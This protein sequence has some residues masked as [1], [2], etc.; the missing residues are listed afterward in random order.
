MGIVVVSALSASA[1]EVVGAAI[2]VPCRRTNSVADSGS[3]PS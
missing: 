2:T 1:Q 3:R